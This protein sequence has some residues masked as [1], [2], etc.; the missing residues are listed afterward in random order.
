MILLLRS[1]PDVRFPRTAV[2]EKTVKNKEK[3][4]EQP[5]T[6]S[7]G[8]AEPSRDA[9][10]GDRQ[11]VEESIRIHEEKGASKKQQPAKSAGKSKR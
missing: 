6:R 1:D 3:G 8:A 10:E 5:K 9:A 2:K 4:K 11:T 7:A